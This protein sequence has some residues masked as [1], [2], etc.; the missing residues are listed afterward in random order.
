MAS[1]AR[2]RCAGGAPGPGR[3][4]GVEVVWVIA[5]MIGKYGSAI[6]GILWQWPKGLFS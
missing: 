5:S 6:A 1:P 2:G 3:T 4:V